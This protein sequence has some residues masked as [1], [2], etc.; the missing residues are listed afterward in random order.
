L[1]LS[2]LLLFSNQYIVGDILPMLLRDEGFWAAFIWGLLFFIRYYQTQQIKEAYLFQICFIVATLFRIEAIVYLFTL[3]TALLITTNTQ[4]TSRLKLILN[5]TSIALVIGACIALALLFGLIDYNHIGRLQELNFNGERSVS[6]FQVIREKTE[7]YGK[8]VLGSYLDKYALQ[9]LLLSYFWI[10]VIKT[11]KVASIP[12]VLILALGRQGIKSIE[13]KAT[14]VFGIVILTGLIIAYTTI[15]QISLLSSR[16]VIAIAIVLLVLSTFA[17][18]YLLTKL[19]NKWLRYSLISILVLMLLANLH[20]SHNIDLDREV[21]NYIKEINVDHASVFYD[22]EN[23]RYY[24][25][26]PYK[27]RILETELVIANINNGE[28]FNHDYIVITV[29]KDQS[30]YVNSVKSKLTQYHEIKTIYGWKKKSKA[31][32]FKKNE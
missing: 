11:L 16:Y 10:V 2:A 3:P 5:A 22:T 1:L 6:I 17:F 32:I 31:I 14:R 7:I 4:E 21:V 20:D 18:Q 25:H 30:E 8:D 24:A 9:S 28:I 29:D 12:A 27:N 19:S 13:A 23:A 26:Q 15:L